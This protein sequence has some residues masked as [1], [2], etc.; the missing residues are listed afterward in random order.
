MENLGTDGVPQ[1]VTGLHH[2][3]IPVSDV[4]N[5]SDWFAATF[6]YKAILISE[7]EDMVTGVLL[8][9]QNRLF[10]GLHRDIVRCSSLRVR[11]RLDSA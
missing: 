6:G 2:V 9:D 4:M 10:V 7:D 5:T 11:H 8:R 1:S 3:R